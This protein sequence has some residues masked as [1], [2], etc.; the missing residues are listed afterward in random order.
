M[1][2]FELYFTFNPRSLLIAELEKHGS[3]STTINDNKIRFS[4]VRL[5][6]PIGLTGNLAFALFLFYPNQCIL[7]VGP[8][9]YRIVGKS[10]GI[11]R[12]LE[13]VFN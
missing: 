3:G 11:S 10:V 8:P 13:T 7:L 12:L 2:E 5:S 6:V 4:E 9:V 1:D